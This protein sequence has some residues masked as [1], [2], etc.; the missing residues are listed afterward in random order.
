M[1]EF[2]L[3]CPEIFDPLARIDAALQIIKDQ[4]AGSPD[5]DIGEFEGWEYKRIG[6]TVVYNRDVTLTGS[7]QTI[8]LPFSKGIQLNRI[9]QFAYRPGGSISART[10]NTR[11]HSHINPDA[12]ADL[13]TQSAVT[14]TA[15]VVYFCDKYPTASKLVISFSSTTADDK[16]S[17]Q[18]Q[19][20]EMV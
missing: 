11:M 5:I 2:K 7:A 16:V 10:Y 19:V 15:R 6:K 1:N 12:Y 18:V 4:L 13:D 8:E 3:N 17:I 20:D 9:E 14:N